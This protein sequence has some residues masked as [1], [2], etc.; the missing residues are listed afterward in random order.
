MILD[1]ICGIILILFGLIGYFRGFARQIFGLLSGFVAVIGAFI[2]LHP[3]YD[4]LYELFLSSIV[5][6][7]GSALSFLTFL[8]KTA[9]PVGK[10][11]GILLA[12]YLC[13]ALVYVVLVLLVGIFWKLLKTLVHP[14]CDLKG[15]RII[16]KILG[17]ILGLVWGILLVIALLYFARVIAGWKFVPEGISSSILN[18]I[19]SLSSGS[20]FVKPFILDYMDKI[21]TY[22]A[23]TWSLLK[24]GFLTVKNA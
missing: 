8:D 10:T 7:I 2:L 17:V 20:F 9:L 13:I 14:I 22:F 12:E 11:T 18:L 3:A 4:L 15:I 24:K 19:D 23:Q 5:E 16:D 21:H 1:I 6:G